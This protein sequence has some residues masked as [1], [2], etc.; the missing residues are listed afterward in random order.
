MTKKNIGLI[1]FGCVGK[2][3]YDIVKDQ[4]DNSVEIVKIAV[5]NKKERSA[6]EELFVYNVNEVLNDSSIDIIVELIDD[7]KVAYEIV[8]FALKKGIPIISA[9]KKMIAEN[10]EE[11][12][13]L[14]QK[15]Q[16]P[17][18]Y[19]GAVCGAVPIIQNLNDYFTFDKIKSISGIFNGSSNYILSKI[20]NEDLSYKNALSQAQDLGFA[21]S[22][23][24]LDVGGFDP[25]YKLSILTKHAF[26]KTID[27]SQVLNIGID[28]LTENEFRFANDYGFKIKLIAKAEKIDNKLHLIVAPYFVQKSEE[29]YSVENENNS[30]VIDS[31]Y[32]DKQVLTGKGAGSFPTGLA[33]YSDLEKILNN[34]SYTYSE[35]ISDVE[36]STITVFVNHGRASI[37]TSLFRKIHERYTGKEIN[38]IIGSISIS[39]LNELRKQSNIHVVLL[40]EKS[41]THVVNRLTYSYAS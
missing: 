4:N 40:T 32:S 15:Y 28:Q 14:Q 29:L 22:D 31:Q 20:F 41:T 13:L 26:G 11:L 17:L 2:G 5:K 16:T 24:T 18:L 23:P 30:V 35:S 38:Y 25:A 10:L 6:P 34:Y 8:V 1:G 33:V 39:Q 36:D 9:N 7:V 21:E 37:D 27:P 12:I 19:E 3:F